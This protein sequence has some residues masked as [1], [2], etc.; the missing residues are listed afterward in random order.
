MVFKEEFSFQSQMDLSIKA[1]R[2][3]LVNTQRVKVAVFTLQL[4]RNNSFLSIL[5][6][7]KVES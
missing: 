7:K 3:I 1:Y 5:K 6:E 2:A 4:S